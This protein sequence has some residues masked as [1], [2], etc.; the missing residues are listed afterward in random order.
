MTLHSVCEFWLV[1][2]ISNGAEAIHNL[3]KFAPIHPSKQFNNKHSDKNVP[4]NNFIHHAIFTENMT[5]VR[6]NVPTTYIMDTV[7]VE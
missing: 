3:L 2:D 1:N 5:D 7:R 6:G 4:S